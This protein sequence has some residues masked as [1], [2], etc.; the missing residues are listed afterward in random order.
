MPPEWMWPLDDEIVEWMDR[1][2]DER[3]EKYGGSSD[4]D[5]REPAGPMMTNE[6]A[7]ERR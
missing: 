1:I 2:V 3:N 7:R 4:R 6:Y 5:D